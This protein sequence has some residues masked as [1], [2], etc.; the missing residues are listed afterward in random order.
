MIKTRTKPQ[1]REKYSWNPDM[2]EVRD[3]DKYAWSS[4]D[5]EVKK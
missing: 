5:I 3:P 4:K 1:L 2:I